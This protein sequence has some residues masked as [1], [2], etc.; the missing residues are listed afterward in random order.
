M[1]AKTEEKLQRIKR[2]ILKNTNASKIILFGSYA[3]GTQ[4]PESDL[5]IC[6][7]TDDTKRKK[8]I[9]RV[10]RR[11]IIDEADIPMDLLVYR[12][13]EFEQKA[14]VENSFESGIKE[15]GITLYG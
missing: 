14:A 3:R 6:I 11:T 13:D 8:E 4:D 7:I 9:L 1:N 12:S 15:S 10:I 2:K 5:D